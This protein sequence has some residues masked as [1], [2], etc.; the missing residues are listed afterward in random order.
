VHSPASARIK[1]WHV[2]R[3]LS[4][5]TN[6]RIVSF[7]LGGFIR[8][9]FGCST[10]I[11]GKDKKSDAF[12]ALRK[13]VERKVTGRGG[14]RGLKPAIEGYKIWGNEEYDAIL[15]MLLKTN[16]FMASALTPVRGGFELKAWDPKE[17]SPSLYLKLIPRVPG[18]SS[19]FA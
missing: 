8:V 7:V 3:D 12:R 19:T 15:L 2:I 18:A 10:D 16:P 11:T 5:V 9:L 6:L 1:I 13:R 14:R 17:R 4:L